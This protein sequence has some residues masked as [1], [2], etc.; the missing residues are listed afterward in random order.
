MLAARPT[1]YPAPQAAAPGPLR[2]F[3]QPSVYVYEGAAELAQG[4]AGPRR[5]PPAS[6]V[7]P[8]PAAKTD[9]LGPRRRRA[10][11]TAEPLAGSFPP[12]G[13]GLDSEASPAARRGH[14]RRRARRR[15]PCSGARPARCF[16]GIM[17]TT[18]RLYWFTTDTFTTW[19]FPT[20]PRRPLPVPPP[21]ARAPG[22]PHANR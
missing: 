8:I 11:R 18:Y 19:K 13:A 5:A 6:S 16:H 22:P 12:T 9:R 20:A 10:A 15:S 4:R 3:Y 17:F 14:H 7:E 1:R 21:R 2:D